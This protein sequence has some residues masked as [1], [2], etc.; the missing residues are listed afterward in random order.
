MTAKGPK[1]PQSQISAP[2]FYLS[3]LTSPTLL[4]LLLSYVSYSPTLLLSYSPTLL[5][6]LLSYSPT[7]PTSPA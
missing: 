5:R 6:L 7:S 4:R 3:S 1:G 2:E